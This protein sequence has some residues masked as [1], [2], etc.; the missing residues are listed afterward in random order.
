M[1]AITKVANLWADAAI[2][3]PIPLNRAERRA[4]STRQLAG[5]LGGMALGAGTGLAGGHGL[6]SKR[7][8]GGGALGLGLGSVVGQYAGNKAVLNRRLSRNEPLSPPQEEAIKL[9]HTLP[10]HPLGGLEEPLPGLK[11]EADYK[12]I[13]TP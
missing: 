9:K 5:S 6:M 12:Q 10:R 8:L 1:K 4:M 11:M 3:P 2:D 7:V 13:L